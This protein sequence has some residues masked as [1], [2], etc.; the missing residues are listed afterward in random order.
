MSQ[1]SDSIRLGPGRTVRAPS[2]GP[3]GLRLPHDPFVGPGLAERDL[4]QGA[5]HFGRSGVDADTGRRRIVNN[6]CLENVPH[7]A[8]CAGCPITPVAFTC[9][10]RDTGNSCDRAGRRWRPARGPR[11]DRPA[12][13]WRRSPVWPQPGQ[14]NSSPSAAKEVRPP[15]GW[16]TLRLAVGR[17]EACGLDS[18]GPRRASPSAAKKRAA[19]DSA[20]GSG[21]M[22]SSAGERFVTNST[23]RTG[24]DTGSTTAQRLEFH[25]S[26]VARVPLEWCLRS[27]WRLGPAAESSAA[28]KRLLRRCL[29]LQRSLAVETP[30]QLHRSAA[31]FAVPTDITSSRRLHRPVCDTSEPR[32][33][34]RRIGGAH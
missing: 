13:V 27:Q 5:Q 6:L 7:P 8:I 16:A 14:V 30:D 15:T 24:C 20:G 9:P 28:A 2:S 25:G 29:L 3:D 32:R 22:T 17:E 11:A 31:R 23:T 33:V 10:P 34:G 18:A 1:E 21:S 26:A 4:G 19:S 12:W